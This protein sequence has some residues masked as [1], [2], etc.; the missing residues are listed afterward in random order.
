MLSVFRGLVDQ[1]T[2]ED[3]DE[4]DTVELSGEGVVSRDTI[5]KM[6]VKINLLAQFDL[7]MQQLGFCLVLNLPCYNS[8]FYIQEQ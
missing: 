8:F 1:I 7:W 6:F 2:F 4:G 5:L 3:F